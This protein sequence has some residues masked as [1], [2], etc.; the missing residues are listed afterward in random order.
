MP[1]VRLRYP[2]IVEEGVRG[3]SVLIVQPNIRR[4]RADFFSALA[5]E[6]NQLTVFHFGLDETPPDSRFA[7]VRHGNSFWRR[8]TSIPRLVDAQ[9][10]HD[11]TVVVFDVNFWHTLMAA[12]I[13]SP[14]R[15]V[16]FW[17]HGLGRTPL[18]QALRRICLLWG[19]AVIV[20]GD[21]GLR[22]CIDAG[23]NGHR[24][25]IARNSQVVRGYR[26]CSSEEKRYF[27]FVGRLQQRK[28]LDVLLHA[29]ADYLVKT[30]GPS[31]DLKIVGIGSI[32]AA[33]S[34]LAGDLG[35]ESR[36]Q[37]IPGTT[38]SNEL[39]NLF[40]HAVA[41]VSPGDVGLG[42]VHSFAFGVPVVT[43]GLD[44][45]GPEF[46]NIEHD[47]NGLVLKPEQ[48]ALTDCFVMLGA[49]QKLARRLGKAAFKTY[50]DRAHPDQMV[51]TFLEALRYA[52][53]GH[54]SNGDG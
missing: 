7:R 8:I 25:F 45:H 41:Y 47:I 52:K 3:L 33:L 32:L 19:K 42:V 24:V 39:A 15:P 16:L 44:T 6:V 9:L 35:V 1:E 18:G 50:E 10:K 4:Y 54:R 38:D 36:V 17:G 22:Q 26:D 53:T 5:E 23:V 37:F 29:Y 14:F 20:Y 48:S 43:F 46:E 51:N 31:L 27:L 49:D 34:K 12:A 30:K 13:G 40:K 21:A 28:R 2:N 11:V